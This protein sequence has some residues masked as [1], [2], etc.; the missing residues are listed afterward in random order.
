M[1]AGLGLIPARAGSTTR[2]G[3][4]P[5]RIGA[6]PRP[7]GEHIRTKS[8]GDAFLGSSP[9]VRGAHER[10]SDFAVSGGLIPARAG[11]TRRPALSNGSNR[12][13]P[14]PCGEHYM[15]G[16]GGDAVVGSSPPVRG[17]QQH[18]HQSPPAHGLIPARAGSTRHLDE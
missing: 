1:Q 3:R 6:H 8:T 9:P 5:L 10:V 4:I 7:C 2:G 14:R 16:G 13:H 15:G 18:K 11:S 17:A 12:A